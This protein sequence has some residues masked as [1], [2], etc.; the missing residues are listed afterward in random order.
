MTRSDSYGECH[1]N[2]RKYKEILHRDKS[3]SFLYCQSLPRIKG[4]ERK[5]RRKE[6]GTFSTNET[7]RCSAA[8]KAAIMT[9]RINYPCS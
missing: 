2:T 1:P 9:E 8:K 5:R 7:A 3:T 4:S 6:H